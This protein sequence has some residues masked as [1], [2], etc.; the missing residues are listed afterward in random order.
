MSEKEKIKNLI[1]AVD[2]EL[3]FIRKKYGVWNNVFSCP[4]IRDMFDA[5]EKLKKELR[6]K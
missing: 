5:N 6:K 1:N 2:R 3:D 4:Y